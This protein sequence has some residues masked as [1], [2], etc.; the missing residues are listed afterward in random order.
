MPPSSSKE[1][2][3]KSPIETAH[4]ACISASPLS[5]FPTHSLSSSSGCFRAEK[6]IAHLRNP[7]GPTTH[8]YILACPPTT[9]PDLIRLQLF[10]GEQPPLLVVAYS[11]ITSF[12][13]PAQFHSPFSFALA[14]YY[15]T[16][17]LSLGS[18]A[19]T[20]N[21]H[22]ESPHNTSASRPHWSITGKDVQ[23]DREMER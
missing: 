12:P 3:N 11:L 5:F 10:F 19:D 7:P 6:R 16:S 22:T 20:S 18:G 2:N 1:S 9:Y 23:Q 15:L 4:P 8:I 14:P 17:P 21:C 13:T